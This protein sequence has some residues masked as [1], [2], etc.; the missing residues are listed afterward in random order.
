MT[1][2]AVR[3]RLQA[4]D[5]ARWRALALS[6][7]RWAELAGGLLAE[8]GPRVTALG[9]VWR[10]SAANAAI[11][12]LAELCRRLALFRLHCW[13]ADQTASEFAAALTRAKALLPHADEA[14]V[15]VA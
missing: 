1:T 11:R 12:R 5:P 7:R 6:W 3:A 2:A 13:H 14:A 15:A 9:E 4:T 10:G 8:L